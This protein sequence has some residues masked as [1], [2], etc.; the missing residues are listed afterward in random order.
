MVGAFAALV[1]AI[2]E[3]LRQ[4]RSLRAEVNGRLSQLLTLTAQYAATQGHAAGRRAAD[5]DN[6]AAAAEKL[7]STS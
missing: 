5:F 7:T 4:V 6:A 1:L 3:V 2:S